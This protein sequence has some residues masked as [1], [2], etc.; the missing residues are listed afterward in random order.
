DFAAIDADAAIGNSQGQRAVDGALD[1]QVVSDFL[2]GGQHLAEEF[3]FAGAQG[4]ATAAVTLPAEEEADQL[5]HGI[6][7]KAAGHDRVAFEMAAEEPQIRMNIELGDDLALAVLAADIG[8]MGNPVDHQHVRRRKLRITWA[9]HLAA[10]AAQQ[11]FPGEG[12]LLCHASS[13]KVPVI[14]S[15]VNRSSARAWLCKSA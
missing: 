15:G 8:D 14:G 13:S 6:Q 11:V 1:V 5:P 12:V 4:A 9:E 7:A 2:R 3:H 10:A